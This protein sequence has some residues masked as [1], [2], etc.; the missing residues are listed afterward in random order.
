MSEP[1]AG[2]VFFDREQVRLAK[3]HRHTQRGVDFLKN[4]ELH[5]IAIISSRSGETK[6]CCGLGTNKDM[7]GLLQQ[8]GRDMLVYHAGVEGGV[9]SIAMQGSQKLGTPVR[10]IRRALGDN[11]HQASR[12][13]AQSAKQRQYVYVYC[14][15]YEVVDGWKASD[16]R[17]VPSGVRWYF[18]LLRL[19]GQAP[20]IPQQMTFRQGNSLEGH[21][22]KMTW[23]AYEQTLQRDCCFPWIMADEEGRHWRCKRC[24]K[25]NVLPLVGTVFESAGT[26]PPA[27]SARVSKPPVP[28]VA[29]P[30]RQPRRKKQSNRY[31]RNSRVVNS[32]HSAELDVDDKVGLVDRT[33]NGRE[34]IPK[35]V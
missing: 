31:L 5:A 3:L 21:S 24:R 26:V 2:T 13:N 6:P 30:H 22:F 4:P 7:G 35:H 8:G 16:P 29:A 11:A 32:A 34:Y 28:F 12:R 19:P 1:E 25:K 33:N 17:W 15:R 27:G 10:V 14:G 9:D 18:K 20:L 23:K